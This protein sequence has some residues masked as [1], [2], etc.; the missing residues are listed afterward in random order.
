MVL[1]SIKSYLPSQ[2]H[3]GYSRIMESPCK[4]PRGLGVPSCQ[5]TKL[6]AVRIGQTQRSYFGLQ[7]V[8]RWCELHCL[9]KKKK[10]LSRWH[11]YRHS[12]RISV[13]LEWMLG[14]EWEVTE[15]HLPPPWGTVWQQN[16]WGEL[17]LSKLTLNPNLP[18]G[19]EWFLRFHAV[20]ITCK[21]RHCSIL[22]RDSYLVG[23][24]WVQE[25]GNSNM[26]ST[27]TTVFWETLT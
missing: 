18:P 13:Q 15:L 16:T 21:C 2:L 6:L 10:N 14:N 27:E 22:L 1:S 7:L 17:E 8:G 26:G 11:I 4:K 12:P 9:A 19:S 24:A 3:K 20:R 25:S 5:E 23:L